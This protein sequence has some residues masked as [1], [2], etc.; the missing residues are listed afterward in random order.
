VASSDN[1][2]V[3]IG[4]A[5]AGFGTSGARIDNGVD[6]QG[7]RIGVLGTGGPTGV[8]GRGDVVGVRG[9]ARGDGRGGEFVSPVFRGAQ[10]SLKPHRM[11]RPALQTQLVS[12]TQ[13]KDPGPDLPM[14]GRLGDIWAS[15]STKPDIGG[16]IELTQCHL[17]LCVRASGSGR[18][19]RWA[20]VLLGIPFEGKHPLPVH[21]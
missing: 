9:I 19:A 4:P 20:E 2:F 7:R 17:W 14:K 1:K 8:E 12:P 3:A 10:I 5:A 18:N 16:E 13:L 6:V 21:P 11:D 15:E